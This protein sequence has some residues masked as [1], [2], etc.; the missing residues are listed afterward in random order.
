MHIYCWLLSQEA[1]NSLKTNS[2][3]NLLRLAWRSTIVTNEPGQKLVAYL[4]QWNILCSICWIVE[5]SV[6]NVHRKAKRTD[7][8]SMSAQSVMLDYIPSAS[9]HTTLSHCDAHWL[10]SRNIL[11]VYFA[12]LMLSCVICLNKIKTYWRGPAMH[13]FHYDLLGVWH[14]GVWLPDN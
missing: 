7:L 10:A 2:D 6:V 8:S 4:C 12:L 3:F 5:G 11:P 9:S 14:Q 13:I 1:N